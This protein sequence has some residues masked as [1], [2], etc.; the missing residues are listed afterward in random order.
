VFSR[1]VERDPSDLVFDV[2]IY[3]FLHDIFLDSRRWQ[4]LEYPNQTKETMSL[5]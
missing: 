3:S 1:P 5:I 4:T 2:E